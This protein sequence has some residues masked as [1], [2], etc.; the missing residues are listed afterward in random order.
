MSAPDHESELRELLEAL[1]QGELSTEQQQQLEKLVVS[2]ARLRRLY[3]R[4][5]HMHV[6]LRR[7]FEQTGETLAPLRQENAASAVPDDRA[8]SEPNPTSTVPPVGL[9][10]LFSGR[11]WLLASIAA[12][13]VATA[14]MVW[15][16]LSPD[17]QSESPHVATLTNLLGCAWDGPTPPERG[18][19]LPA[20]RIAL[21]AGMA[22]ITFAGGAVAVLE[23]PAVLELRGP[24]HGFLHAGR[25]VMR[26][27]PGASGFVMETEKARLLDIGTEFGVGVGDGGDTLVQVF[28]GIVV[29]DFHDDSGDTQQRLTAGQTVQVGGSAGPGPRALASSEQ[30]FVRRF[31]APNERGADWLVPYNRRTFDRVH[32]VPA[33]GG[34]KVNGDLSTWN[35]TGQ[36]AIACVEPYSRDYY[37]E[38]CMMYDLQFL[39]IGAHVGDPAPMCSVFNPAIDPS[40]GWKGGAVQVRICADPSFG[41][42]VDAE[43]CLVRGRKPL[44]PQDRSDHLVHLTMW[45]YQPEAKPCLHVNY[46]MDFHGDRVNPSGM[47]A[48][49]RKDADGRGY[50][51]TYAIPWSVLNCHARPPRAGDELGCCWNVHWSDEEGR[52]WKG[53]LVDVTNPQEKG[54]TYQTAKTWGRAI[55]QPTGKLPPGTVVP[56]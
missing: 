46:G 17:R 56:R 2:D 53:Y 25:L 27:P 11:R 50:T 54:F 4:Y 8:S 15:W 13:L 23:A 28:D 55:F 33:P 39:Y 24:A 30:R 45:Y 16:V 52:L 21:N 6:C 12:S 49:Y 41:W 43:G 26:V 3:V 20:G 29:A 1:C 35:R 18:A 22:E 51:M 48:A 7:A 9:D 38:G 34:A 42:P 40:V 10:F 5:V 14:G 32:V 31:P 19:K 44:R 36:F 37:V 47:I